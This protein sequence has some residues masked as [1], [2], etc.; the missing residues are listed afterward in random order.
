MGNVLEVKMLPLVLNSFIIIFAS[1]KR[2]IID[3]AWCS[4]FC[5]KLLTEQIVVR[6]E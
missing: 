4:L 5:A 2:V 6:F 3:S 1:V